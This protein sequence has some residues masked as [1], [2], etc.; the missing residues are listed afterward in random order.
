MMFKRYFI[1]LGV[2]LI[3]CLVS[4]PVWAEEDSGAKEEVDYTTLSP[5][6][7]A[8][9]LIFKTDSFDLEQDVQEGGTARQRM[10]QDK[11]QK[12]CSQLKGRRAGQEEVQQLHADARAS[13]EY[14]EAGIELGDWEKG[15]E[16]AR[17]GYGYR[18]GHKY[19]SHKKNSVGGNCYACHQMD[20]EEITFGTIGPSLAGYGKL[21]GN[22]EAMRQYVYE[23]IYNP[24]AYFVCT[25]MPRFGESGFLTQDDILDV[26]A[27]LLDPASP[28]NANFQAD[29]E[30]E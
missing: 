4:V 21:R 2:V 17:S 30:Q 19:D 26:M 18:I 8:D 11:L 13:I 14:P 25:H 27:Y 3:G 6:E 23:V 12:V 29:S 5:E 22:N 10:E 9:H 1:V 28:V 15:N 16:I 7:L 20:P 24:H